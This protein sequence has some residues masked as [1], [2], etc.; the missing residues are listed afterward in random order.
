MPDVPS[1]LLAST[2]IGIAFASGFGFTGASVTLQSLPV[3][4]LP[5]PQSSS[6]SKSSATSPKTAVTSDFHLARQWLGLFNY[7]RKSGPIVCLGSMISL[8]TA[9]TLVP[10]NMALGETRVKLLATA[11]VLVISV[12]P[13]TFAV[14]KPTNDE[15]M[16][17]AKQAESATSDETK[18]GKTGSQ[19]KYSQ[20]QTEDLIKQW[21]NLNLGRAAMAFAAVG[22][23]ITALAI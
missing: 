23:A 12:V 7:G 21:G 14:I 20:M 8:A 17:R 16:K 22:T 19:G 11:A 18:V 9:A 6:R 13:Y 5:A 4:L 10:K 1:S 15:L 2:C 3:L